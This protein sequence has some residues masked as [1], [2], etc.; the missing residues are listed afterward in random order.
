[1]HHSTI[2]N[3]NTH[4]IVT[5]LIRN[6][7]DIKMQSLETFIRIII[8]LGLVVVFYF[9]FGAEIFERLKAKDIETT[10]NEVETSAIP[11]PGLY[12]QYNDM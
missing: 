1:M 10:R 5:H 9:L 6:C 4:S 7:V 11:S 8:S 2:V 12:N 3:V